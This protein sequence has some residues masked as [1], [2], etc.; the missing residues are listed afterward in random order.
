MNQ[1]IEIKN[2]KFVTIIISDLNEAPLL[3]K[4]DIPFFWV[5]RMNINL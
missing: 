2:K 4:T 3:H 1:N 5:A